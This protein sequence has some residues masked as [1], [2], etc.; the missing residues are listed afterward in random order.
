MADTITETEY[1]SWLTPLSATTL[2]G[3]HYDWQTCVRGIFDL[4]RVDDLAVCFRKGKLAAGAQER[5]T[6]PFQILARECW[7]DSGTAQQNSNF[8]QTGN[9]T[10]L[11][12]GGERGGPGVTLNCVGVRFDPVGIGRLLPQAVPLIGA[13]SNENR[14]SRGRPRKDYWED[15]WAE[16]AAQI[17]TGELS[18]AKPA[19]VERAMLR[20]AAENGKSLSESTARVRVSMLVT[21]IQEKAEK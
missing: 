16:I 12:P 15:L 4:I 19:I 3:K 10:F 1:E 21:R 13:S 17:A 14:R 2:L 9:I 18:T 6:E 11:A 8:W 5:P 7:R 20:W